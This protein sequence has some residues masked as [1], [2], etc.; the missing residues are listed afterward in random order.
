[1]IIEEA[2]RLRNLVDRLLG[3]NKLRT[4]E[5]VNIHEVLERVRTLIEAETKG[6]VTLARDYDPSLPE[7][8]GDKE[9]LIQAVFN[10]VRN[11][12]QALQQHAGAA[13]PRIELKTRALRQFTIG[14]ERHRLVCN[15]DITDNGPGIPPDLQ[16]TLFLP[17][18]SGRPEGSGLGLSIAQS[19]LN[20]HRGLIEC[21]SRPGCT[22]FSMYIPL[23]RN[24]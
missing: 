1:M 3:P 9:Q 16:E 2:D 5:P 23:E 18:V 12:V 24:G 6:A 11:A 17:M 15:V 13:P 21:N 8:M 19:I 22:T 7:I 10:I 20:R 14:T 4:P